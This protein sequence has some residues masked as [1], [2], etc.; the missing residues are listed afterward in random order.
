MDH[1][2]K[3]DMTK[4]QNECQKQVGELIEKLASWRDESHRQMINILNSHSSNIDKGF[5]DIAVEFSELQAQ[6][7]VL[8]NERNVLLETIENLN[9]EIKQMSV[10]A[11]LSEG[12]EL[13][14]SE[15]DIPKVKE[16]CVELPSE[17]YHEEERLEYED[18]TPEIVQQKNNI[19]AINEHASPRNEL[20]YVDDEK[21]GRETQVKDGSIIKH[22]VTKKIKS[23]CSK[24]Q[25]LKPLGQTDHSLEFICKVCNFAFSTNENLSIHSKNVHNELCNVSHEDESESK[26][27]NDVSTTE[28]AILKNKPKRNILGKHK[29][30][31][32][33]QCPFE[34][35]RRQSLDRHVES[36]HNMEGKKFICGECGHA[37]SQKNNLKRHRE[38]VHKMGVKKFKCEKCPFSTARKDTFNKHIAVV[39]DNIRRHVCQECGYAATEKNALKKHIDVVHEN[40][41]RH[42]CEECGYAAAEK[43]RLKKH[44]LV[45]HENIR[46]HV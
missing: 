34:S 6:V 3:G 28:S 2:F 27:Q 20:D 7:S 21:D 30:W 13:D 19:N 9:G 1:S 29:E 42:V 38:T 14:N 44:I 36:V 5:N 18:I 15:I 22:G 37:A 32:C 25:T 41:R 11:T 4:G 17:M 8:R 26:E 10:Q 16:E 12:Q 31:K 39:H 40:I 43:G 23:K 33:E 24:K 45:V 35:S 46:S